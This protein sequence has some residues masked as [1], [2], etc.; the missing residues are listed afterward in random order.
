MATLSTVILL[1]TFAME[2]IQL[3]AQLNVADV[4]K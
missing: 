4:L 3:K 2:M 1:A